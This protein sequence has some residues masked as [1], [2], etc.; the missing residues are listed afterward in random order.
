MIATWWWSGL[1]HEEIIALE[2]ADIDF[3]KDASACV[4]SIEGE[5]RDHTKTEAGMREVLILPGAR[6]M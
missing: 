2:W 6:S 4:T 1:R 5:E 3:V